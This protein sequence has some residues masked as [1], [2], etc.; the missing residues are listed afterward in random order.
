MT[1]RDYDLRD[2]GAVVGHVLDAH[3]PRDGDAYLTLV[4]DPPGAQT[5]VH[6]TPVPSTQWSALDELD[7]SEFLRG[8]VHELAIDAPPFDITTR[9]PPEHALVTVIARSGLAVFGAAELD[10]LLAWRYSNHHVRVYDAGLVLVTEHGW[11][12]FISQRGASTP[13]VAHPCAP[14]ESVG[15]R[16]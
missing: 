2:P 11:V 9:R 15:P 12:D 13:S 3:R 7:R 1:L 5:V 14:A 4:H 16:P 6:V 8:R 10:W